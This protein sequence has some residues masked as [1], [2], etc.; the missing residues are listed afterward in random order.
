MNKI[1][2]DTE[3]CLKRAQ[4]LFDQGTKISLIYAALEL[5]LGIEYRLKQY[6]EHYDDIP[7]KHKETYRL[8]N[9]NRT[10]LNHL[11]VNDKIVRV[12]FS[13][14]K[15]KKPV[16][17]YYTPVRPK[18]VEIGGRLGAF[19]HYPIDNI[20]KLKELVAEGIKELSLSNKGTLMGPPLTNIKNEKSKMMNM[21]S[22]A[23]PN[24][25]IPKVLLEKGTKFIVNIEYLDEII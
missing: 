5:R 21:I 4:R 22:L 6:L 1:I 25:K 16:V 13:N 17:F 20:K 9:L 11:K 2:I 18:L 14:E 23:K 24:V 7:K 3:N 15:L 12:T 19:L 10:I 8:N